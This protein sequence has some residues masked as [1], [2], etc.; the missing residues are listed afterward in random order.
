[1]RG[2]GGSVRGALDHAHVVV[3][4]VGIDERAVHAQVGETAD[5][6]QRLDAQ[7]LQDDLQ[8]GPKNPEQRRMTTTGA[9]ASRAA[10]TTRRQTGEAPAVPSMCGIEAPPSATCTSMTITAGLPTIIGCAMMPR[11]QATSK[12]RD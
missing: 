5:R 1:M 6:H 9:P 10:R 4:L 7:T 11:R 8:V 2:A 12:A 3:V